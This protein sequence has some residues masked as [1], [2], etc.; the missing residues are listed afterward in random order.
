MALTKTNGRASNRDIADMLG[1]QICL[2][3]IIIE[4][5]NSGEEVR[6]LILRKKRAKG[7]CRM[8][9]T[10][11]FI[12]RVEAKILESPEMSMAGLARKFDVDRK[13]IFCWINQDLQSRLQTGHFLS[14]AM[15]DRWLCLRFEGFVTTLLP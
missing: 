14:G 8:F 2:V 3:Q 11:D 15:K 10:E 9:R 12:R 5:L 6:D 4:R 1:M 7:S 13:T